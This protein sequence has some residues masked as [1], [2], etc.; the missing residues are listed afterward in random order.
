MEPRAIQRVRTTGSQAVRRAGN[1]P[2]W[3]VSCPVVREL[4]RLGREQSG[5]L[6]TGLTLSV[7][8]LLPTASWSASLEAVIGIGDWSPQCRPGGLSECTCACGREGA[9]PASKGRASQQLIGRDG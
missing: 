3:V 7:A 1:W 5:G 9:S 8:F 2:G 4:A 6:G